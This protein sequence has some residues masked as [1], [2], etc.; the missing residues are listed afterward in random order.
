MEPKLR[1]PIWFAGT[2]CRRKLFINQIVLAIIIVLVLKRLPNEFF[3]ASP[4]ADL[5]PL[6]VDVVILIYPS[7]NQTL[8]PVITLLQAGN[9]I[10]N[11]Q[12][13]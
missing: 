12:K 10:E 1:S 3:A 2:Q 11:N 9:P 7:I 4:F 8:L 5:I 6:I 13:G